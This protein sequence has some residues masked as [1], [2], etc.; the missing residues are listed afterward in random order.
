VTR[1]SQRA[2]PADEEY[3]PITQSTD[4]DDGTI[5]EIDMLNSTSNFD[6]QHTH[7]IAPWNVTGTNNHRHILRHSLG[8]DHSTLQDEPRTPSVEVK[9]TLSQR[10]IQVGKF[11]LMVLERSLVPYAWGQALSGFVIYFGL[12]HTHYVTG[13]LAHFISKHTFLTRMIA[14]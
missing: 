2:L 4:K 14:C 5:D 11:C 13:V 3:L 1:K 12:G 10:I 7:T 9:H 6:G 8:S